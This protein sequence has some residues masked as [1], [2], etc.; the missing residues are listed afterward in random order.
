MTDPHQHSPQTAGLLNHHPLSAETP[1]PS[2]IG[3]PARISPTTRHAP[4]PVVRVRLGTWTTVFH[5]RIPTPRLVLP[6]GTAP[7][8]VVRI[9]RRV[10]RDTAPP[11]GAD[12]RDAVRTDPRTEYGRVNTHPITGWFAYDWEL[13]SRYSIYVYILRLVLTPEMA[14]AP[15]LRTLERVSPWC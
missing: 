4:P 5:A 8:P 6:S 2:R 9:L 13:R 10:S 15:L 11:P 1:F 7:A 3:P 14:A 12:P